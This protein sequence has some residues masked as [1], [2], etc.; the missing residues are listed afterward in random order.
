M[1]STGYYAFT[2]A[3]MLLALG[4]AVLGARAFSGAVTNPLEEVVTIVRNM[5]AH[6]GHAEL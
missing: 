3:L 4:G 2:L 6:G 1:Q 5:S